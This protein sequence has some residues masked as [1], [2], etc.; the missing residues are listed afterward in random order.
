MTGVT[1]IFF[2][3]LVTA[4]EAHCIARVDPGISTI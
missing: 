3:H 4:I 1:I 2:R